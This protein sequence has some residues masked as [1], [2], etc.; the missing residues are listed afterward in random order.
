MDW[1]GATTRSSYGLDMDPED[2]DSVRH[3]ARLMG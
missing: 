2:N 1:G 3:R